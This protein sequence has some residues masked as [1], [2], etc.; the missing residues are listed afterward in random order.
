MPT[1]DIEKFDPTVADL[2]EMVA[3]SQTLQ[4]TD[5]ANNEQVELAHKKR[6]E[7]RDARVRI[8]KTGKGLRE[9]AVAFQKAA[10]GKEKELVAIIEPE[11]ARLQAFEDEAE[12]IRVREERK[13]LLPA[14]RAEL[15][16]IKD[17][18]AVTDDEL[19]EM[20]SATFLNYT[21]HRKAQKN[22]KDRL[23]LLA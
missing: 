11:E 2:K 12:K 5:P 20:D 13:A 23:E 10:I 9:E 7:L 16:A 17:G 14:R 15:D 21:N 1:L 8:T 19:L 6:I 3:G 22:E 18:I 4:L